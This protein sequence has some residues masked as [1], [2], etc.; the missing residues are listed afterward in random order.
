MQWNFFSIAKLSSYHTKKGHNK[1][2]PAAPKMVGLVGQDSLFG[3][4]AFQ[5]PA[6]YLRK[7]K[8]AKSII[9]LNLSKSPHIWIM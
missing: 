2:L 1:N 5:L 4:Y 6:P 7:P 3:Y 8:R 9:I